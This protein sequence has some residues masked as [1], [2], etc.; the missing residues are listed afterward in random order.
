ME[1]SNRS[2][3]LG[4]PISYNKYA[5]TCNYTTV[6]IKIIIRSLIDLRVGK[7]KKKENFDKQNS[8]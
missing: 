7:K 2:L 8:K 6:G 5:V 4:Y 3:R 1:I